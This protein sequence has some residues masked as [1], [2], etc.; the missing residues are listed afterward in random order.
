MAFS[1]TAAN[2]IVYWLQQAQ[3]AQNLAEEMQNPEAKRAMLAVAD[4]YVS[5]L[6]AARPSA[7]IGQAEV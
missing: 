2:W 6:G 3:D 5:G 1:L 4:G 7:G